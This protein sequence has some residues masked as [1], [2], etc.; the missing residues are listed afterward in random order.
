ME[1]L[2]DSSKFD[3]KSILEGQ[4]D[5]AKALYEKLSSAG[6]TINSYLVEKQERHL[7]FEKGK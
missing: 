3:V 5:V 6:S 2:I 1:E 4:V 7:Y